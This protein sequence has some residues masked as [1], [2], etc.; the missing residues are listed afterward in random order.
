MPPVLQGV[1]HVMPAM[2]FVEGLRGVL[3]RGN[4]FAVVWPDLLA[5]GAF[6][7]VMLLVAT[8][9]FQRRVA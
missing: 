5:M 2:Y 9:R 8:K 4:G 7:A 6:F 1:A 3:L